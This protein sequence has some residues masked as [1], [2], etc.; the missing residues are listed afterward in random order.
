MIH[1]KENREKADGVKSTGNQAQ[2]IKGPFPVESNK[3]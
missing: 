3:A 2:A 1:Y